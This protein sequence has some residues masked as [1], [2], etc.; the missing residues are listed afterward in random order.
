MV[1]SVNEGLFERPRPAANAFKS[2]CLVAGGT[3]RCQRANSTYLYISRREVHWLYADRL[4]AHDKAASD[5]RAS[6][7]LV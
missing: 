5:A 2:F 1:H 7:A 4:K 6:K 3:V